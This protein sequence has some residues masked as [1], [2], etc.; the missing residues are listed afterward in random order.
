MYYIIFLFQ[1]QLVS[2][3][4]GVISK[5]QTSAIDRLTGNSVSVGDE[6]SD[7]SS[8]VSTTASDILIRS[9]HEEVKPQVTEIVRKQQDSNSHTSSTSSKCSKTSYGAENFNSSGPQ[10]VKI[11]KKHLKE[12]K[13]PYDSPRSVESD[14]KVPS[15]LLGGRPPH[16]KHSAPV[17]GR[18][19]ADK[20][21]VSSSND[22]NGEKTI[23][24]AKP[25]PRG[26]DRDISDQFKVEKVRKSADKPF[27]NVNIAK[28]TTKS[29]FEK[30]SQSS[31]ASSQNGKPRGQFLGQSQTTANG[32]TKAPS[33]SELPFRSTPKYRV[34]RHTPQKTQPQK[35]SPS[36]GLDLPEKKNLLQDLEDSIEIITAHGGC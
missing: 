11:S 34:E 21:V 13:S 19:S 23:M 18:N 14:E 10:K 1:T 22:S 28:S 27:E 3:D 9:T 5:T 29:D 7:R 36:G 26:V 4:S 30:Q 31:T 6:I 16:G 35:S 2:G 17:N 32:I 12:I 25:F 24:A 20:E 15:A 33:D 8:D